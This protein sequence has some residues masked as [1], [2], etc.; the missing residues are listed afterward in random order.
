MAPS[1]SPRSSI[2]VISRYSSIP[3]TSKRNWLAAVFWASW[4]LTAR[5]SRVATR[6]QHSLGASRCAW[7]ITRSSRS[8]AM[9]TDAGTA[10]RALL[11]VVA[12]AGLAAQRLL[13]LAQAVADGAAD[14]G[15]L[16]GAE[17]DERDRQDDDELHGADVGHWGTSGSA[18]G[19]QVQ[20]VARAAATA[21]RAVGIARS[22]TYHHTVDSRF[23]TSSTGS[24]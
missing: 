1:S 6:P 23:S 11:V 20:H 8:A 13:E 17:H 4:M 9:T 7:A 12:A 22:C 21:G 24:V 16:L 2:A 10:R 15:E 18:G 3:S 19:V 5:P 14:L